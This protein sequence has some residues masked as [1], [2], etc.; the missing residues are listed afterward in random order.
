[1][2]PSVHPPG[3][4]HPRSFPLSSQRLA[5]HGL[6][7]WAGTQGSAGISVCPAGLE[8]FLSTG[9]VPPGPQSA[10]LLSWLG[11]GRARCP[12][13]AAALQLWAP[14]SIMDGH[15]FA[16]ISALEA[17]QGPQVPPQAVLCDLACRTGFS[18]AV[19]VCWAAGHRVVLPQL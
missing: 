17:W 5:A 2:S 13:P 11:W 18:L 6:S 14:R 9:R 8:G 19:P 3:W 1:M 10:Q 15:S 12:G 7:S 4:C 16:S